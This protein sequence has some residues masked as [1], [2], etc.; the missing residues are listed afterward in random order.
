MNTRRTLL[1]GGG[2]VLA[3]SAGGLAARA[4]Q[5]GLLGD[6]GEA[7]R[8][9][10]QWSTLPPPMSLV[11]AGVLAASPHNSQPWQFQLN[12]QV[13]D[14]EV[15]PRR[16]LGPVD[17]FRRQM[18][19]GAGCAIENMVTAGAALGRAVAVTAA[20][21]PGHPT[22]AARLEIG[23]PTGPKQPALLAA[24]SNRHT[25]RGRYHRDR[26]LE[27]ALI[28][29]LSGKSG[30]PAVRVDL[31]ARGEP[32]GRRFEAGIVEATRGLIAQ[33]EFMRASDAWFRNTPREE[34]QHRDGPSLR[35]TGMPAWKLALATL[36]PRAG[37]AIT[38]ASWLS[39]TTDQQCGTSPSFGAISL[40]QPDDRRQLLEAG[41]LWQRLM[42]DGVARG[43][44]FQPLDQLLELDDRERHLQRPRSVQP[45]LA[46]LT[47]AGWFPVMTFRLGWPQAPAPPS[48]R[49][50]LDS[51]VTAMA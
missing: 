3:L 44:A 35:C 51:F 22:M 27:R 19:L 21:D 18:W 1:A 40:R 8:L 28:D 15:D 10:Q 33:P 38:H 23:L 7:R 2:G 4:W 42:L 39:M 43:L 6:S 26:A 9:W 46:G 13:I 29:E 50:A 34:R 20:P 14:L 41:R 12:D 31:F 49:R 45:L 32:R 37:E 36:A 48:S 24:I 11:A 30:D 47:E 16:D 17:P 25:N 5:T